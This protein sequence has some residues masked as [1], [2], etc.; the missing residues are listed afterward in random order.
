M[1]SLDLAFTI[2]AKDKAS[3]EFDKV[4]DAADRTGKK[5]S[6][7]GPAMAAGLAVAGVAVAGF[8]K[9]GVDSLMRIEEI[10]AQTDA[11]LKSTGGAA[12]V[13]REHIEQ[14]AGSI[15]RFSGVEA[16]AIQEGQ[17]LLLTFTNI[18]GANFDRAT[19]S[20]VDM[21]VAMGTDAKGAAMQL[22]KA[23]NDPIKGVGTLGKAGVQF[24]AE[25]KAS[26]KA[27]VAAGD[28]AGAQKVILKELETQFGGSAKAA[29][30]TLGGQLAIA[31]NRFGEVQEEM[32]TKLIP[33]F[34]R[35]VEWLTK[36]I[37]FVQ[38]NQAVIVPLVA[39]LGGLAA[40]VVVVTSVAKAY[41]A[42]QAAL[43]VVLAANPVGLVIIAIAALVAG[44]IIA[45]KKSE[46]FR[47][48]VNGALGAIKTAFLS[49]VDFS[50]AA[51][52]KLLGG[53]QAMAAAAGKLP[54]PLGAPFR[55]AAEAIGGA[56][57]RVDGLRDGIAALKG[58]NVDIIARTAGA[59]S[60]INSVGAAAARLRDKSITITTIQRTVYEAQRDG[61][62]GGVQAR[63][64]GGP[65]NAFTP[66]LVGERGPELV[67]PPRDGFVLTAGQTRDALAGSGG[68]TYTIQ[69][70]ATDPAQLVSLLRRMEALNA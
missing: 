63:A 14:L 65:M 62:G 31:K 9:G 59:V 36:T 17:N 18:Q 68:N 40:A 4:G 66:Y 8:L 56:K 69:T 39:V 30:Q 47:D 28:A 64:G 32:A 48:I 51:V 27:M 26:I 46:T 19:Q 11:V 38:R 2:L 49:M 29:G 67:V 7:L 16:E 44:I 23:L 42:V 20:M 3:K 22:G 10:G 43:N 1:A 35:F 57:A 15:E 24:T 55:A 50:L 41:A 25:Q 5:G 34:T 70:T 21:S 60:D 58:K 45:Y 54:G 6:K 13:T 61:K 52:S 12:G 37:D 33:T 53:F